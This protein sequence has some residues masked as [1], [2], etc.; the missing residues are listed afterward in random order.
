MRR[1]DARRSRQQT[2]AFR[3]ALQTAVLHVQSAGRSEVRAGDVLAATLQETKSFAAQLLAAQGV[4]RLDIL[5]FI[6]HGIA[7]VPADSE[8]ATDDDRS[9]PRPRRLAATMCLRWPET[10]WRLTPSTSPNAPPPGCST[11]SSAASAS[12]S[13]RSR[14]SAAGARTVPCSS[15]TRGRQDRAWPKGSPQRLP[16]ARRTGGA[17]RRGSLLAR[18]RGTARRHALPRRLRRALQGGA[19]RAREAR[20]RR[21]SSSTSSTAS[22]AR[23]RRRAARWISRRS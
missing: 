13:A 2:L 21:F 22:S 7:K 12:C 9:G 11:R 10:R 3:R 6:S 5:N 16:A 4:T 1:A 17:A 15:G 14:S 20:A 19:R 18:H 23:A 8:P